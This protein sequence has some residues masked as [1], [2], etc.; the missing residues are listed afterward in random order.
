[1][2]SLRYLASLMAVLIFFALAVYMSGGDVYTYVDIPSVLISIGLPLC[3]LRFG[4]TFKEMG[5][6]FKASFSSVKKPQNLKDAVI[7]FETMTKYFVFSGVIGVFTG[8]IAILKNLEDPHKLGP[9]LAVAL[10]TVL[11]GVFL[12]LIVSIPLAAIAKKQLNELE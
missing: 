10:I 4:W 7:F 6:C 1:M 2:K 11:Y 12:S 5:E 3:M 8:V 9:N